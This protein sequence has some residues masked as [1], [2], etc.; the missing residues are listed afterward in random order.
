[1]SDPVSGLALLGGG[2]EAS[3]HFGPIRLLVS[4]AA[5]YCPVGVSMCFCSYTIHKLVLSI[6]FS[7]SV[8]GVL[9]GCDIILFV[10]RVCIS[11]LYV[12]RIS[13]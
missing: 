13:Y 5:M 4:C 6:A 7:T 9:F 10:S 3:G 8:S 1:M 12:I 2:W 11:V